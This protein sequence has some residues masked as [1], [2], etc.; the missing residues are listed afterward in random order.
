[1]AYGLILKN[2]SGDIVL[3]TSSLILNAETIAVNTATVT[4]NGTTDVTVP[5]AHIPEAVVIEI[6][7]TGADDI[8]TTTPA[9]DT[10][11]LTN[12]SGVD[13][14]ITIDTWRLL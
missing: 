12:T 3:N 4:A 8:G 6:T 9:N 5:D 2:S 14:T 13:R 10:V 1:M 11:R 7:G